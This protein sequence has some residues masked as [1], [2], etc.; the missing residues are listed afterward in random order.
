LDAGGFDVRL[1]W[2]RDDPQIRADAIAC[3]QENALLPHGVAP[4]RR[5]DELIAAAYRDDRLAAVSTATIEWFEP[6]RARFAVIRGATAPEFRRTHAQL[7]LAVPSRA[8]LQQWAKEHPEERLAGGVVFV[9]QRE[10]GDFARLP[11][12]PESGLGLIGYD[13]R[14]RQVRAAWFDHFRYDADLPEPPLPMP[15]SPPAGIE[16]RPAW[17]RGDARIEAD[18][19]AFW[20]RLGILPPGISP[21]ARAGQL[22]AAAYRDREIVAVITAEIDRIDQVRARLA[23]IRA[24]VDPAERRGH[25]AVAMLLEARR[26]LESWSAENPH[27]RLGGLGAAIEAPELVAIEKNPFW[28]LSQFGVIGFLPS[29][30]QIRVS[31]FRDFRLD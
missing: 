10:W 29:G 12:W 23:V 17:L 8:A 21:R 16:L 4:E 24:A 22:V 30:L 11:V 7:A 31:W 18:A 6:L 25:I 27:E 19:I 3:W 1:A 9:E 26:L 28:P 14:G 5:A 2:R 20:D 15:S 13:Q